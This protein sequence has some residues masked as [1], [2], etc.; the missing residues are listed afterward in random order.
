MIGNIVLIHSLEDKLDT[1][2]SFW[3]FI[4]ETRYHCEE[5][6][7]QEESR[8]NE[9]EEVE[10][11]ETE[12]EDRHNMK[13]EDDYDGGD[14]ETRIVLCIHHQNLNMEFF[15]FRHFMP[16]FWNVNYINK[17]FFLIL[18]LMADLLCL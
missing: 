14:E 6:E 16:L 10:E 1:D 13:N 18:I 12:D 8:S 15:I 3:E 11:S 17:Y 2:D 4:D 9:K 5:K 7:S